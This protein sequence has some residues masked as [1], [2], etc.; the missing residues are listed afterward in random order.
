MHVDIPNPQQ[1]LPSPQSPPRSF[2]D[3]LNND[4]QLIPD[5]FVYL[6]ARPDVCLQ[7]LK[8]R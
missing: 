4:L 5:G 2:D 6:R 7:R 8:R 3:H 1:L